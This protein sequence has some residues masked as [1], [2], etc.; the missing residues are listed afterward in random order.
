MSADRPAHRTGAAAVES[1][2]VLALDTATARTVLAVGRPDG[3]LLA[4]DTWE[5]GHRHAEELLVR[6]AALLERAGV[7]RP[8]AGTLGG[9][10]VGTGPGGFTGLRVGL[11]TARGLARAAG[12]PLVGVATGAALEAAARVAGAVP[13]GAPAAILLP[14]GPTGRYLVRD[15][16]AT[17]APPPGE[18]DDPAPGAALIAVDLAGRAAP[19][20][21]A[22]G[23][24]AIDGLPAALLAL[25][26]ARLAAGADDG[27]TVVPE[28]VT[29]PRG[30][31]A[32]AREVEWLPA[33]P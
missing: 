19:E 14:A 4:T 18:D 5:A 33:R 30:I 9:V 1:L 27:S 11:A 6:L 8:G 26:C 7:G 17:L 16:A 15:G 2:P 32:V 12:A 22:R 31:A 24:A 21:L 23:A 29:L 10:V 20:A 28:Y 25:G 3:T 13:A